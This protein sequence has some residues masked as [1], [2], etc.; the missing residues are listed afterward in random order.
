MWVTILIKVLTSKALEDLIA[1]GL[2]KLLASQDSG[3]KKDLAITAIN[4]VAKSKLNPTTE[5]MF[6]N[7]LSVLK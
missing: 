7:V 2:N 1:I 5:D 6:K 4:A 3:I